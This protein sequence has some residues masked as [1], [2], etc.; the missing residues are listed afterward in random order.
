VGRT[1]KKQPEEEQVKEAEEEL[2]F[3]FID[4]YALGQIIYYLRVIPNLGIKEVI[5]AKIRTLYKTA[6][7]A[8]IEATKQA[9]YIGYG[10]KDFVFTDHKSAIKESHKYRVREL[11]EKD[12]STDE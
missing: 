9:I 3:S 5:E 11:K 12:T 2:E 7:V 8:C 1:R 10:A 6:M 4:H